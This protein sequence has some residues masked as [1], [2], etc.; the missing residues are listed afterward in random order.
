MPFSSGNCTRES[1]A[2][3]RRDLLVLSDSAAHSAAE[4]QRRAQIEPLTAQPLH[5][6]GKVD[7]AV[8]VALRAP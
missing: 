2:H 7:L 5:K 8:S 4:A 1:I 6:S 3:W